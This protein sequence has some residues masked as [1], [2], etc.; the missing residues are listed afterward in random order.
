MA[1]VSLEYG[2]LGVNSNTIAPGGIAE[3]EG[4]ARLGS[5]KAEAME[6]Y[7]K[8]IPSGRPGTTRDIADA[9][10]FLFSEAGTYVNGHNLVVDGAAWRRQGAL[11]VGVE[12]SFTYPEFLVQGRIS[13]NLKDPRKAK[14]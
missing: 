14:L 11:Q 6:V 12:P 8:N 9:T 5:S 1:S 3:T 10:V 4:L 2:P 7:S 13:D